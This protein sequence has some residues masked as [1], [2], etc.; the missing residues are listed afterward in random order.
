MKKLKWIIFGILL[1]CFGMIAYLVLSNKTTGFDDFVYNS[2]IIYRNDLMTGFFKFITFFASE[3]MVVLVSLIIFLFFKNKKY[4]MVVTINAI[5]ILILN[6]CLKLIFMRERPLD[7]MIITENGY[8]FPSGH[9]MAAL[10]FYGFIIYLLWHMNLGKKAKVIF[11]ILLSILIIL[12]GMSR[13]YLGVHYASDVL[14]GYLVSAAYLI[15]YI[16]VV[17]R[18][19]WGAVND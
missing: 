17:K 2:V 1:L 12:I 8:S 18:Y 14:A 16:T 13:I 3:I 7:I 5:C 10:G 19:L 6:V 15:I 4:G 9:A 11:S